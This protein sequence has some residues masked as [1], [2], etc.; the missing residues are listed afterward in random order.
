[1]NSHAFGVLVSHAFLLLL[2]FERSKVSFLKFLVYSDSDKKTK[3]G[4]DLVDFRGNTP[5][6]SR[7]SNVR[8]IAG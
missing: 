5:A 8:L 1:M 7:N 4:R 2:F 6:R 3:V